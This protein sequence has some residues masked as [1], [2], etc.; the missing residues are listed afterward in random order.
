L[1]QAIL[2]SEIQTYISE[3]LGT[4]SSKI[5]FGKSPFKEVST[6]ELVEQ[7]E[8]KKRSE[9]KLPLWFKTEGIYFPQKLAIEQASSEITAKYKSDLIIGKKV[10]DATG[11]LGIDSYYFSL[12]AQNVVHCEINSELSAIAKHNAKVLDADNIRFIVGDGQDYILSATEIVDS[13]YIDPS[14]RVNSQKVFMLKDCEPDVPGN[15]DSLLNSSLRIILKTSPL[16]DIQSGLKELKNVKEIHIVSVKNDCKELLWVIEK[17]FTEAEPTIFCAALDDNNRQLYTFNLSDERSFAI[18]HFSA[19]LKYIYEPDVSLLKA[20]CFKLIGRDFGVL[21]LHQHTHLYTSEK[22]NT[23][24][25]GRKF[26]LIKSWGYAEFIKKN[27]V[28]KANIISR[29]FPLQ[30]HDLK[31]KHKIMD[32]GNDYLLFT[33]GP[34]NQLLVLHCSRLQ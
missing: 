14:R 25:I 29:N 10:V 4:E 27:E 34:E 7:I 31:K 23:D 9:K 33:T 32:G 3:N 15:L 20:G 28:E 18:D 17:D 12:K 19:P 30:P 16:L 21:K 13:I 1:N 5:L 24:F 6:K 26:E 11:G 8:S 22:L 2:N